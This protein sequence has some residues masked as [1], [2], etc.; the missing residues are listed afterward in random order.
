MAKSWAA[1]ISAVL[2]PAS[3]PSS[4]AYMINAGG[5]SGYTDHSGN[6]WSADEF[7]TG[8]VDSDIPYAVP[9]TSDGVL[10]Y[11]RRTGTDFS[12]D[13]PAANGDYTV[14]LFFTDPTYS[15]AGQRVFDVT[16]QG[17]KVLT[18]FDIIAAG[19]GRAPISRS[20]QVKVT[21]GVINLGFTS[22][23]NNATLSAIKVL[24]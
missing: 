16:A 18:D 2:A 13:L 3:A 14:Q 12:Y 19:G 15:S 9:G 7:F 20:F 1:A 22:V 5:T 23:L 21:N 4:S 24:Q 11:D 6:T 17:Q 8:G 10:F